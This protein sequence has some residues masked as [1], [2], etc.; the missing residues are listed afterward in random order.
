LVY[1]IKTKKSYGYP[2]T[3]CERTHKTRRTENKFDALVAVDGV[4]SCCELNGCF[5]ELFAGR[6]QVDYTK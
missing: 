3:V 2:E 6:I 5:I 1:D 4:C